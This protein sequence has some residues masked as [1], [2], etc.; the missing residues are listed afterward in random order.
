MV[1]K[2]VFRFR[3]HFHYIPVHNE[4]VFRQFPYY[5]LF[6]RVTYLNYDSMD[7]N[8]KKIIVLFF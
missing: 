2:D 6:F 8:M 3:V 4:P 5:L 7:L 1:L